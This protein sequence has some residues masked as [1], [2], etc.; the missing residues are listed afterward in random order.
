MNAT[1]E[2]WQQ[3]NQRLIAKSIGEMAYEQIFTVTKE[4]RSGN[5]HRYRLQ[6]R[7]G[8]SYRFLAWQTVWDYLRVIAS[9]IERCE[10]NNIFLSAYDA[11]QFFMDCQLDM[12]MNSTIMGQFLEEM[13]QTL[14][15]DIQVMQ[16]LKATTAS[17]MI[18]CDDADLQT[19]LEGH[20][21]ALLN[22]G[23]LGWGSSE[24]SHYAPESAHSFQLFWL[25]AHKGSL[26][27][28][29]AESWDEQI[30]LRH[31][32]SD[33][34]IEKLMKEMSKLDVTCDEYRFLPVHPWQWQHIIKI[35]FAEDIAYRHLVPLG[36]FGD[37]YQPLT[38][39]RTLSNQERPKQ[40][41]IKLPV[42]ILNTSCVR[43]LPGKYMKIGPRL[44][45]ILAKICREDPI[46][47]AAGT[48]VLAEHA[49][50]FYQHARYQA[51]KGCAYRLQELL[52]AV[53]RESPEAK[54][55]DNEK[56]VLTAALLQKDAAGNALISQ[57]ITASGLS[58]EEWLLA[59]FST[60]VVPLYH[61]Q[62]KY[63][64][65]IVAHG[66][67]I[68]IKLRNFR[69][70]GMFLKDFQGDLRLIDK[71]WPEL[72]YFD[73]EIKSTLTRLPA[74]YLIHDLQTG[75]LITV[76]RFVSATLFEDLSFPENLFYRILADAVSTYEDRHQ[77]LASRMTNVSLLRKKIPRVLINKVRFQIGYADSNERPLP[78]LGSDLDN[79]LEL[80][81]QT[82]E[83]SYDRK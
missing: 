48:E 26:K 47:Q 1:A 69:P 33:S 42:S 41:H 74:E 54:L 81:L 7:S 37:H 71:D 57:Y 75:H 52:G 68:G 9:S 39:L 22:K 2:Q 31:S 6:L 67:N 17:A 61:L 77:A 13:H 5:L 3:A 59:Y 82:C 65:G 24:L 55:Q 76:L 73:E 30:L 36:F 23:R 50:V 78:L 72:K 11:A 49:A 53:W 44:S 40:A 32:F 79:P 64:I 35:Q 19:L 8:V 45:S 63:G 10:K 60:V 58:T 83:S 38:S 21:K 15:A 12:A 56:S 4:E 20:P 28:S 70:V 43:G 18:H 27:E 14:Y 62:C 34:E 46:L 25:A 29:F 80:A 51:I 66:Q 16:R